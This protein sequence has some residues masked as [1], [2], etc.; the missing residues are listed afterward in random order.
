MLKLLT[1]VPLKT[2]LIALMLVPLLGVGYFAGVIAADK[3]GL[4]NDATQ[5]ETLAQLGVVTGDLL[6]ETQK[7][8]GGSAVYMT[9]AGELFSSELAAQHL[10]TD[11]ARQAF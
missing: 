9:S 7:E 1:Q 5:L 4:A 2:K 3:R 10:S 6:H 11:A 8:R